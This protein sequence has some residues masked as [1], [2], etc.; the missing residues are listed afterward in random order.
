VSVKDVS[1]LDGEDLANLTSVFVASPALENFIVTGY[2]FEGDA[3]PSGIIASWDQTT[4]PLSMWQYYRLERVDPTGERTELVKIYSPSQTT[5]VDSTP[6]SGVQYSFELSQIR[7]DGADYV[8]SDEQVQIFGIDLPGMVI[9]S[10]VAP[11][12]RRVMLHFSGA[13]SYERKKQTQ[14]RVPLAGQKHPKTGIVQRA[15]PIT[16]GSRA[17]WFI[18]QGEFN[19]VTDLTQGTG[20]TAQDRWDQLMTLDESDDTVCVRDERGLRK[21]CKIDDLKALLRSPDIYTVQMTLTEETYV[22]IYST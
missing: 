19:L 14:K 22:E 1:N 12:E 17:R 9:S 2:S 10:V 20:I 11:D 5:Y 4:V 7:L 8:P 15:K 3:E 13:R 16:I 6:A 18:L 21:F